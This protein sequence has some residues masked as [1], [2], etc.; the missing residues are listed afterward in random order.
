MNLPMKKTEKTV[1]IYTLI[2][3]NLY[4]IKLFEIFQVYYKIY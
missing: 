1:V 3:N 2:N 4:F